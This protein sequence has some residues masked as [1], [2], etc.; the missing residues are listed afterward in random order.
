[1]TKLADFL[2]GD[3]SRLVRWLRQPAPWSRLAPCIMAVGLCDIMC[4]IYSAPLKQG[5]TD[6]VSSTLEGNFKRLVSRA[7]VCINKCLEFRQ[8][9]LLIS[10]FGPGMQ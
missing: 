6:C 3:P 7:E 4:F 8:G 2:C 1:M 5:K 10:A 9:V